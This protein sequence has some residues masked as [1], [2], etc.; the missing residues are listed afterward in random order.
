MTLAIILNIIL[1]VFI[2]VAAA[3]F[4]RDGA[5]MKKVTSRGRGTWSERQL[6]V[7]LLKWGVPPETIFHDLY[8]KKRGQ[9]GYSQIDLVV[10]TRG[11][12][13]VIEVKDYAGQISGKGGDRTW[14]QEVYGTPKRFYNPILQ[15]EGHIKTLREWLPDVPMFSAVVF[16]GSSDLKDI[17]DVP[18]DTLVTKPEG[19]I[20]FLRRIS[21][22]EPSGGASGKPQSAEPLPEWWHRAEQVLKAGVSRTVPPELPS[23]AGTL[24]REE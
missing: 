20:A 4:L 9:D 24:P 18:D 14:T 17:S 11:G 5:L 1:A 23:E 7:R 13:A 19:L 21:S 15:N 3:S 12:L 16:Y 22:G 10:M 2:L 6:V 8:L